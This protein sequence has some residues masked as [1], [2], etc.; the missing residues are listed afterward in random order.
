MNINSIISDRKLCR[1]AAFWNYFVYCAGLFWKPDSYTGGSC[2]E[3][4]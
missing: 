4:S 3:A 2:G 1:R